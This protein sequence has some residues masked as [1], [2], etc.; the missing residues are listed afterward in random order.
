M[1]LEQHFLHFN[2]TIH[3]E[4]YISFA[5]DQKVRKKFQF[6]LYFFVFNIFW[7]IHKKLF[8][9]VP[10][11][12]LMNYLAFQLYYA[13]SDSSSGAPNIFLAL[14]LLLPHLLISCY[15]YKFQHMYNCNII[16]KYK[17]DIPFLI[18]RL[19]PYNLLGYMIF[20]T[21]SII[22]TFQLLIDTSLKQ[23][24]IENVDSDNKAFLIYL[25][26]LNE[27]KRKEVIHKYKAYQEYLQKNPETLD[28][29]KLDNTP[30][31]AK[32]EVN[33]VVENPK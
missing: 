3:S 2:S 29:Q 27:D 31:S 21:I 10:A 4:S 33:N 25:D 22:A 24:K 14:I 32:E 30:D 6:S 28:N 13:I 16:W 19:R 17:D 9:L 15:I 18:K 1:S 23:Q 20:A 26:S 7:L 11:W 8:G 12:F 5:E